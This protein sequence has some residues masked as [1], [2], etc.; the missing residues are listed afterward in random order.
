[1]E[2]EELRS[3]VDHF[4]EIES[5]VRS[6]PRGLDL[7]L[8]IAKE[9]VHLNLGEIHIE[10]HSDRGTRYAFSVPLADIAKVAARYL[11]RLCH[12]NGRDLAASLL[13]A[14]I[15]RTVPD[16]LA[17][18][19]HQFLQ[20][21]V[22]CSDLIFRLDAH[23]WLLLTAGESH[24]AVTIIHRIEQERLQANRNRPGV[25]LPEI[26]LGIKDRWAFGEN[27]EMNSIDAD[28]IKARL[29]MPEVAP[30]RQVLLIDDDRQVVEG[31]AIRLQASGFDVL[32]AYDGREGIELAASHRPDAILLD[33]RMPQLDG[34]EV[35]EE[36]RR[37]PATS[38]I[39]V[40][41]MSA[42]LADKLT[43]LQMGADHFIEKPYETQVLI[44][45]VETMTS[46][47]APA[48]GGE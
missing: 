42:R 26:Q 22:R 31:A 43:A 46:A 25:A 35:L 16:D 32:T 18:E 7:G 39:P 2:A 20:Q 28:E 4:R 6:C 29:G 19:V 48:N 40:A 37:R 11:Q 14:S 44:T 5:N 3:T 1:M 15:D 36:L 23:A 9:L 12:L 21:T 47:V 45:A 38:T 34:L 27:A 33:L 30:R 13:A 10:S 8:N 24:D 41:I 17:E